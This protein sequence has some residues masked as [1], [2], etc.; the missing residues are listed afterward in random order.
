ME[1]QIKILQQPVTE[2]LKSEVL[3]GFSA[4]AIAMTGQDGKSES[5]AFVAMDGDTLAGAVVVELFWGALHVKYVYVKED[6]RGHGLATRLM[7]RALLF[8][9][10]HS[11]PFAFVETMSFQALGFYQKIGFVLKRTI[12]NNSWIILILQLSVS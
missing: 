8:G 9:R 7:E 2:K 3:K 10:E 11:C 5:V 6:Y 4:H 1:S 12:N